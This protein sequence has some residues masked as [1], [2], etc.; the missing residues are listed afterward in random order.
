MVAGVLLLGA[1]LTSAA[2]VA[3]APTPEQH[4]TLQRVAAAR[5]RTQLLDRLRALP[6]TENVTIG[7]WLSREDVSQRVD[8]ERKLRL[9]ARTRPRQGKSRLYSDAVCEVDLR[10]N[11]LELRDQLLGL[12]EAD[13]GAAGRGVDA[14]SIKTA[15]RRWPVLWATGR[16]GLSESTRSGQYLGWEDVTREGIHLARSAAVADASHALLTEAGRLRLPR[17]R[18][19]QEFLDASEAIRATI[20]AEVERTAEVRVTFEP[21][22]IAVADARIS[23]RD[24]LRILQRVHQEH[25]E[26]QDFQVADFRE[27][28]LLAGRK[29]LAGTGLATPPRQM[30]LGTRY[31]TIEQ[32]APRWANQMLRVAGRYEANDAESPEKAAKIEAARLDG[33]D[34]LRQKIEKLVIQRNV[35]VAEFIGYHQGLKPDIALF[36]G[37]ARPTGSPAELTD[38]SVELDVELPLQRLWEIVRR[39]MKLVE[40]EPQNNPAAPPAGAKSTPD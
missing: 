7:T 29:E 22:Q 4:K 14:A 9:W 30:L 16:A 8:L 40:M 35:T 17:A 34:K 25:Y 15:A 21:D 24:L 19:L 39:E 38:G 1:T 27:M 37:G 32:D 6:I 12:V 18:R 31:E 36:L 10:I 23:M 13:P 5:A 33:V 26:G 11:P 20:K 28:T 3:V 2:Q